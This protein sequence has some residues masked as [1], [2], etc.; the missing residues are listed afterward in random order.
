MSRPYRQ[1]LP[2]N[3]FTLIE[4]LIVIVVIGI[5][6]GLLVPAIIAA[7]QNAR[8]AAVVAEI[9]SISNAVAS[10][11]EKNGSYFPSR[12][13]LHE[14]LP[15]N[16]YTSSIPA[17]V[18]AA[19]PQ[20]TTNVP[21]S[22]WAAGFGP[23]PGVDP[24]AGNDL[25]IGQLAQRSALYMQRFFPK[26]AL[27]PPVLPNFWYDFNGNGKA[28]CL[29]PVSGSNGWIYLEG[30]ECLAFF[31]GGIP[32]VTQSSGA[33]IISM[34]GFGKDPTRP[35]TTFGDPASVSANLVNQF[36]LNRNP[37]FFEFRSERLIDEDG[38]GIPG[39]NDS[40]STGAAGFPYA[41][42]S[43]YENNGYDPNDVNVPEQTL[44]GTGPIA[45]VFRVNLGLNPLSSTH[46]P[47]LASSVIESASPNPY[48]AG[49]AVPSG[50]TARP[51]NFINATT[52][53][54]ISAGRDVVY[55]AGGEYTATGNETIPDDGLT[56][57]GA[58]NPRTLEAD[59]LTNFATSKLR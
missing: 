42:F 46:F 48:T 31:L 20:D 26:A 2:R 29:N 35:F 16:V 47:T 19:R 53:Q 10:F 43:A 39:Y 6:I 59:N 55:G 52:F 41:Y 21:S 56:Y 30:H 23:K 13:I 36:S 15:F 3:G 14:G 4:L 28:D 12:I 11:K 25:T 50:T 51:A 49:S 1:R 9:T 54:I 34:Q 45:R 27:N 24:G 57:P 5:L 22:F 58:A 32:A 33:P 38:D 18:A 8:N 40:L 44:S 37:S 7:I 17:A